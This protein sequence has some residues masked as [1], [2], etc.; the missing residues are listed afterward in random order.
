MKQDQEA[1]DA[2]LAQDGATSGSKQG[3]SEHDLKRGFSVVESGSPS[4]FDAEGAGVVG[5]PQGWER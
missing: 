5:R 2:G 3:A 4:P 1:K